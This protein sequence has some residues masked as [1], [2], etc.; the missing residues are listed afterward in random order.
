MRLKG[1][2]QKQMKDDYYA[3]SI[4]TKDCGACMLR[5]FG[6]SDDLV[7]RARMESVNLGIQDSPLLQEV[8]AILPKGV[9]CRW[10]D[11]PPRDS[12]NNFNGWSNSDECIRELQR[13]YSEV[14]PGYSAMALIKRPKNPDPTSSDYR[15]C[16]LGHYV[17]MGKTLSGIPEILD[18]QTNERPRGIDQIYQYLVKNDIFGFTVLDCYS[19]KNF[20][21]V[22]YIEGEG[23]LGSS[24]YSD[25]VVPMDVEFGGRFRPLRN[26]IRYYQKQDDVKYKSKKNKSKKKKSRKNKSRK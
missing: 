20:R 25:E 3:E 1:G 10:V 24:Q 22:E 23:N 19:I 13:F 5:Y 18:T 4:H 21:K 11:Y 12:S 2:F 8:Q 6:A 26:N 15:C 9:K 7:N 17:A 16:S 14:K